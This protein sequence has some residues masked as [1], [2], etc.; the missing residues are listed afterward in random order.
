MNTAASLLLLLAA[1]MQA[2]DDSTS[3]RP[4]RIKHER[5]LEMY[6]NDAA[7]YTIYRGRQPQ[8]ES[9]VLVPRA[10]L[11]LFGSA[12]RGGGDGAVFVWTCRGRAEVLG[13]FFSF[14]STGRRML[15]HESHSLAPVCA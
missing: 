4:D 14:P 13:T 5:L 6:T 12:A 7:G 1:T 15:Y 9:R 11:G 2:K 8:R 3:K 10:G